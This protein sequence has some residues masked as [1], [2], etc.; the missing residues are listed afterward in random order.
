MTRDFEPAPARQLASHRAMSPRT[1]HCTAGPGS[2]TSHPVPDVAPHRQGAT[3]CWGC[4]VAGWGA[5][6]SRTVVQASCR[7][8][9][10]GIAVQLS[11]PSL[12]RLVMLAAKPRPSSVGARSRM[13]SLSG[14]GMVVTMRNI[15]PQLDPGSSQGSAIPA[16][17]EDVGVSRGGRG[18]WASR[19]GRTTMVLCA[20]QRLSAGIT[21]STP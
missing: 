8:P 20:D 3:S 6:S 9:S 21:A 12:R 18:Y 5:T 17:I 19:Y 7:A 2:A 13:S 15:M 10:G 14:I 4:D 11:E 16:A 1:R